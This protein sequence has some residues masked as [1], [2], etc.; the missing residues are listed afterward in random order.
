MSSYDPRVLILTGDQSLKWL[1]FSSSSPMA[2]G[3]AFQLQNQTETQLAQEPE[4][5]SSQFLSPS[6]AQKSRAEQA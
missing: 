6:A 5:G 3:C 1:Q 4:K 2:H